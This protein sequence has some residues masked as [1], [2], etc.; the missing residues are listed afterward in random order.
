MCR[1]KIC[2][3]ALIVGLLFHTFHFIQ[4]ISTNN[5]LMYFIIVP[6]VKGFGDF[7]CIDV[8]AGSNI[9]TEIFMD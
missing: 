2:R 4:G 1:V 5:F 8:V 3:L 7:T 6:C 9:V